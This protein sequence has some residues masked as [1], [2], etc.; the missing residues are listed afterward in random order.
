MSCP[1]CGAAGGSVEQYDDAI[2]AAEA[3]GAAKQLAAVV[4]WLRSRLHDVL[5]MQILDGQHIPAEPK[6]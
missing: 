6:R 3:R 2:A 5:A 4:A 1:N